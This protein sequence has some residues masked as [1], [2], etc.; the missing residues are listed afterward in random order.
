MRLWLCLLLLVAKKNS[1][2]RRSR[3]PRLMLPTVL[4]LA[5]ASSLAV[6]PACGGGDDTKETSAAKAEG[7]GFEGPLIQA[8]IE[9]LYRLLDEKRW[10]E[11]WESYT[12]G[13]RERCSFD[14]M[15]A[16]LSKSNEDQGITYKRL[17]PIS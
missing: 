15:V 12:S 5:L 16:H 4:C 17:R 9:R 2:C 1:F 8:A 10:S 3:H 14:S 6:F 11:V 13:W 7:L